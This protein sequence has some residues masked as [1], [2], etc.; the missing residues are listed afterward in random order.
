M[1]ASMR[2][3]RGKR[4]VDLTSLLGVYAGLR[5]CDRAMVIHII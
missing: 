2:G 3:R 4:K 1:V 5:C